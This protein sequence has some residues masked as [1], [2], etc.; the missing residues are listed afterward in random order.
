ML[1]KSR[2]MCLAFFAA[3]LAVPSAW[4]TQYKATGTINFLRVVDRGFGGDIN[5]ISVSGF[6]S[7]GSCPSASGHLAL[8]MRDDS[9]GQQMLQLA[10]TA[11]LANI[12]VSVSVDDAYRGESNFCLIQNI[13]IE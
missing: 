8:V 5:W 3:M 6:T 13:S 10:Q 11:R 1:M 9:R 4:A 7:A 2:W 12:P